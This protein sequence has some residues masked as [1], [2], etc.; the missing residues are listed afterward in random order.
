MNM[1]KRT[2]II[3]FSVCLAS[4][5]SST[6]LF[7][8]LIGLP[9]FNYPVP[10]SLSKLSSTPERWLG[11]RVIVKGILISGPFAHIPEVGPPPY[12]FELGDVRE[13]ASVGVLWKI[14]N[15]WEFNNK[16]VTIIGVVKKGYIA[17]Y[18]ADPPTR[19]EEYY[20]EAESVILH[21]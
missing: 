14:E 15:C 13:R 6:F 3:I 8:W 10:V 18:L 16:N 11:R 7:L 2:T 17:H 21:S 5:V 20:V 1:K 19:Q 9:P 4:V 12:N